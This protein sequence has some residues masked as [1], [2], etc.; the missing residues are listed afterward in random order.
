M[1]ET[2]RSTR[3]SDCF[4]LYLQRIYPEGCS[5]E[6]LLRQLL[7]AFPSA[8]L[9]ATGLISDLDPL[10]YSEGLLSNTF[11]SIHAQIPPPKADMSFKQQSAQSEVRCT[12]ITWLGQASLRLVC[13]LSASHAARTSCYGDSN[14]LTSW[15]ECDV[16]WLPKGV[17]RTHCKHHLSSGH[18]LT[19]FAA[20][21][22]HTSQVRPGPTQN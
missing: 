18:Y 12:W 13:D 11:V 8:R 16:L 4:P 6:T 1:I 2:S 7:S 15:N 21:T 3:Q 17:Y 9:V 19:C 22:F 20:A 5:L 10:E 14:L